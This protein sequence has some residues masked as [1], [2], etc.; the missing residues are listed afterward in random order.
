MA[1]SYLSGVPYNR[2]IGYYNVSVS[3][4][5]GYETSYQNYTI[6][7][8]GELGTSMNAFIIYFASLIVFLAIGLIG[9]F[10]N[11]P[12]ISVLAALGTL[13]LAIPALLAFQDYYIL[14]LIMIIVN[15]CIGVYGSRGIRG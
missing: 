9:F 4:W 11:I 15:M 1:G 12:F 5:D 10:G 13:V 3:V 8:Y 2:D 6:Q 7:V 14:A